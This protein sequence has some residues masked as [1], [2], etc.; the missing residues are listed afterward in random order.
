MNAAF[1]DASNPSGGHPQKTGFRRSADTGLPLSLQALRWLDSRS[2]SGVCALGGLLILLI[3]L[4]S[5]VSGPQLSSSLLYLI[6]VIVVTRVTGFH[7]GF[8][9]ALLAATVWLVVDLNGGVRFEHEVTPYW[10]AL[11]RLGTFVVAVGLVTSMR[12]LTTHLEDRVRE[13]TAALEAQ[14]AEKL[15]LEKNILEISDNERAAIGQDLHDGLCQQLV[16]AAFSCNM[17]HGNLRERLPGDADHVNRIADMIDDSITQ[18]RN[19]ARGL[20]PVRLETEGLEM[21]L[22]ELASTMNRRFSISCRV[23]CPSPLPPCGHNAGIHLYRI[24]QEAVVNAAKHAGAERID[25]TVSKTATHVCLT[26]SDD[27]TGIADTPSNPNGMGL[28]IMEYR[29]RLIGATFAVQSMPSCGGTQV[30]CKLPTQL[31]LS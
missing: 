5:Y 27:G 9:A 15:E 17:L 16:S 3:G 13:R 6:P 14:I 11:M 29:A 8:M 22:R 19:L 20:Y 2:P 24:A 31:Y 10:N 25:L 12:S 18:A 1:T 23:H 28:R 26:I 4:L 30:V 21:A 7:A